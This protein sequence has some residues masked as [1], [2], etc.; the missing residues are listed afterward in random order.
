MLPEMLNQSILN[1][2]RVEFRPNTLYNED[3]LVVLRDC[4][5][6]ECVDL[7]YLDPPFNSKADYNVLF[8]EKT[9]EESHAQ[10]RAF[11]DFW[12][13]DVESKHAYNYLINSS[14]ERVSNLVVAFHDSLGK[15]DMLAYVVMMCVRLLE[16]HRVLKPTGSIFLHCDPTASHY[17]KLLMDSIFGANNFMNEIVWKRTSAHSGDVKRFGRVHDIILFYSK[18]ENHKFNAQPQPYDEEY[19]RSH[20]RNVDE[21]GRRWTDSDLMAAGISRGESGKP[22]RGIDPSLAGNHWKFTIA[23]LDDLDK[24]GRIYFPKSG[25]GIPRYK[26][27]LDEMH[28]VLAQDIWYDISPVNSQARERLGFPTQKPVALLERII[29]SCSNIGDLILDPFCGCGTA[30]VAAQ[31]LKREWIGIDITILAT[32]LMMLR[33]NGLFPGLTFDVQG[34]PTDKESAIYLANKDRHEFQKWALLRIGAAPVGATATDPKKVKKGADEGYDGWMRFQNGPDGRVEKIL[35]QVKSGHVGVRD[36]RDFRDVVTTKNAA[37]GVFITLEP[38]TRDMRDSV[39]T[40]DPFVSSLK[41]EYP[42]LQIITVDQLLDRENPNLPP[43]IS[44]FEEA[45]PTQRPSGHRQ[46]TLMST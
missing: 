2:N 27:Y 23:T 12:K 28:G 26:R 33:L 35:V 13:W 17:L 10:M 22:W 11:T 38:A 45:V 46:S 39:R 1:H 31:N 24:R 9:G 21:D 43:I 29:K 40:T 3:N 7:I 44:P 8:K 42:K 20:Y 18:S 4:F 19:L 6:N 36:I 15:S 16:L 37:M 14:P 41:I 5:P 25:K 34:L 32:N 30:I